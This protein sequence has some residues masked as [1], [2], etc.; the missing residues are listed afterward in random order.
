MQLCDEGY[1]DLRHELNQVKQIMDSVVTEI[2]NLKKQQ[3]Q[4]TQEGEQ[5]KRK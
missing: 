2:W 5:D 3:G 4:I 1:A